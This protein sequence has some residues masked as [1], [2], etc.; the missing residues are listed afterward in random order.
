MF[1]FHHTFQIKQKLKKEKK[2][3]KRQKTRI[4]ICSFIKL[5]AKK[6]IHEIPHCNNNIKKRNSAKRAHRGEGIAGVGNQ[7]TGLPYGTVAYSNALYESRSAHSSK[8]ITPLPL[9][10]LC[11]SLLLRSSRED[12]MQCVITYTLNHT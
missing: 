11:S 3:E 6:Q 1:P 9:L 2:K 8:R 12:L 10:T 5:I 4:Q 7:E